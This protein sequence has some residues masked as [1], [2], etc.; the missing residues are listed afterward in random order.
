[1]FSI[2][3]HKLLQGLYI[4][5]PQHVLLILSPSNFRCLN[6]RAG[7]VLFQAFREE[8]VKCLWTCEEVTAALTRAYTKEIT[9]KKNPKKMVQCH[10]TTDENSYCLG[11]N[12]A[13]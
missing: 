12:M 7:H 3:N 4:S 9:R 11:E 5:T 6:K 2:S 10:K 8:P 1:M 13:V